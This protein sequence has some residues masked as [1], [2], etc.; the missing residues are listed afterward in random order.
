MEAAGTSL[1]LATAD[2]RNPARFS[3]D[4]AEA[5]FAVAAE[6][7]SAEGEGPR[8]GIQ[9]VSADTV[10][11]T[12]WSADEWL[13]AADSRGTAAVALTA[14]VLIADVLQAVVAL[15]EEDGRATAVAPVSLDRAVAAAVAGDS[16]PEGAPTGAVGVPER[17]RSKAAVAQHLQGCARATAAVAQ[18]PVSPNRVVA[19]AR[20]IAA[21]A[22]AGSPRVAEATD[23][24][25]AAADVQPDS[26]RVAEATD[27]PTAA[28]DVQADSTRVA[29]A[30]DAPTTAA[31]TSVGRLLRAEAG[32]VVETTCSDG[33]GESL[34]RLEAAAGRA[35]A[36]S[37]GVQGPQLLLRL[38]QREMAAV[39]CR[40]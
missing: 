30:T 12:V 9:P 23:A 2:T 33:S 28:A 38:F 20:G 19:D 18:A 21:V 11:R 32:F 10:S 24:P 4:S 17:G 5:A 13:R 39:G 40:R 25:T 1:S 31:D 3:A 37:T 29:E 34:R 26:P 8:P 27:A 14:F 15:G 6:V 36:R 35:T 7:V 16:S 22:Q